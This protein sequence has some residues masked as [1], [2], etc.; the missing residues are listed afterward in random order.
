MVDHERMLAEWVVELDVEAIPTSV[1]D[2]VGLIIADTIGVIVGG[3]SNNAVTDLRE[4]WTHT[5]T[6]ESGLATVLGASG[7][8]A[9]RHRAA[10]LNG[11]G[12]TVLELDEGHRYAAGHPA[13]HILPA[14]LADAE[15]GYGCSEEFVTAFVSGYEV[16][17]RVAEAMAPLA[18]GYHPHGVWG[19]VGG[20]A[21]IA[22][23]RN[24]DAAATLTALQIAANYAQHTRFETATEGAT[25]RHTFAGMSNLASLVAADQAEAGFTGLQNGI[26]RHLTAASEGELDTTQLTGDIGDRWCVNEGYFKQHAACRYTH[27]TL[28]ALDHLV[29]THDIE[30]ADVDSITVETY[31]AAA[32]LD[33]THPRNA[34]QAKFSLPFAVATA[35]LTG[36]TGRE[37]FSDAAIT[38]EA[39]ELASRVSV[40]VASDI[41]DRAPNERGAR[42]SV[43]LTGEGTVT[44]EVRA[45]RGGEADPFR[46]P[47]LQE[48]FTELV[49]PS[50]GPERTQRLWQAATEPAAPRVL[51]TLVRDGSSRP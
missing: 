51:C 13:I 4:A 1:R 30:S 40:Q 43:A 35:L 22:R 25:V 14:L 27:A 24:F 5:R 8:R 15:I 10:F 19:T 9:S 37:A 6:G 17:V 50:L 32:R 20:A 21:A 34:L 46:A 41:D 44:E 38:P 12:G 23:R 26:A 31:E 2:R 18:D 47:D 48:K 7:R 33:E 45:A 42:I 16:A 28:D 3:A 49:R 11:T 29:D 39:I 36:D